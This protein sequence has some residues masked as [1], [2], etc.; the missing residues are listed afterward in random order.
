MP[1]VG[2]DTSGR[3]AKRSIHGV[4]ETRAMGDDD[5]R[6]VVLA[7]QLHQE[8]LMARDQELLEMISLRKRST[9]NRFY[10]SNKG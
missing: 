9:K 2:R 7:I 6:D 5:E 3:Q 10:F 4:C 1:G 8:I